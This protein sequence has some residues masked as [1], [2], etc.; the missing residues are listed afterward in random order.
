MNTSGDKE[1]WTV[2]L[3]YENIDLTNR[4]KHLNLGS[5]SVAPLPVP[6]KYYFKRHGKS[7]C[8]KEEQ[9][10]NREVLRKVFHHIF[11]YLDTHLNTGKLLLCAD[12]R[13][14]QWY[15]VFCALIADYFKN[16]HLN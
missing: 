8:M 12:R 14:R 11:C 13:I 10:H 2:Y 15:S 3:S 9:I 16:I 1:E 4:S 6:P 5:V 7:T